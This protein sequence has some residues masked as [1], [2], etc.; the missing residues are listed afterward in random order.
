MSDVGVINQRYLAALKGNEQKI[1]ISSNQELFRFSAPF[2]WSPNTWYQLKARV[3]L[4]PDGS[5]TIRAKAW[6]RGE[7]EPETWTIEAP[8]RLANTHGSP[9]L[10]AFS[11]QEMR[12]YL[13]NITVTPNQ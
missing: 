2:K 13:D 7:P 5:G 4:A 6:K 12:V 10:F 11:P 1:E 3:D 9:G 8:H